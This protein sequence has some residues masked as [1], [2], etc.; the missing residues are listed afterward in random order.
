MH[1][2]ILAAGDDYRTTTFMLM[3]MPSSDGQKL[4]GKVPIIDDML[5]NEGNEQFSVRITSISNPRVGGQNSETCV[6]I[7]DDDGTFVLN[8][9]A[10][11]LFSYQC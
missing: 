9:S 2:S 4:C 11:Y 10:S 1:I 5:A 8:P 7:I 3:F 6:T